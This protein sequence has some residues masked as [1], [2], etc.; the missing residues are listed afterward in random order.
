MQ[1]TRC[2]FATAYQDGARALISASRCGR[3]WLC[4]RCSS[5]RS[6]LRGSGARSSSRRSGRRWRRTAPPGAADGLSVPN[7]LTQ[8][9]PAGS[10][11]A[12][13]DACDWSA[14]RVRVIWPPASKPSG[15]DG[16]MTTLP[17]SSDDCCVSTSNQRARPTAGAAAIASSTDAA[18]AS[19]PSSSASASASDAFLDARSSQAAAVNGL[20]S[21]G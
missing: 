20:S 17:S 19:D 7:A 1:G 6:R 15:F 5:G 4:R 2:R 18:I 13:I 9:A 3:R 11:P 14:G 12:T 8:W 16:S 10:R 21:T